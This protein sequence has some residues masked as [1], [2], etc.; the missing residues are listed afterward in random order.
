M[1]QSRSIS[2]V[3]VELPTLALLVL[4]AAAWLL[5]ARMDAGMSGDDMMMTP[6]TLGP[7]LVAWALMMAAMMLPAVTPVVRLYQRAAAAGRVAPAGYFVVAYLVV[8]S[9]SGL[10]A[11]L[12]WRELAMPLT[13]GATWALRLAG[14]ALLFAGI[15][16]L[17]PL[18]RACLRHCR[19]P[20]SYFLRLKGSLERPGG[21]FRAGLLHA[22][23]CC[24]CCAAL[25]VVLVAVAAMN[26]W[27][28]VL[29]AVGVFVERNVRWGTS[30]SIGLGVVLVTLGAVV[31]LHPPFLSN[32]I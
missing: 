5:T 24:G 28:A 10:P 26:L 32:L 2:G 19:S 17:T 13:D 25:M 27:W 12:L 30:F 4:A 3:R 16:Q 23:Y 20:M 31:V 14:G 21:A 11:Y 7:F 22:A 6:M 18:K 1:N 15:Y 9:L 29:I 8:W